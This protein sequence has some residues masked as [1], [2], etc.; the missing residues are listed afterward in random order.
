[1]VGAQSFDCTFSGK[2]M[3]L[4]SL[5]AVGNCQV[6]ALVEDTGSIVWACL[7]SF[8]SEPIF[9]RLLDSNG[10]DFTLGPADGGRGTQRYLENPNVLETTFTTPEGSF[11]VLDFSP[12]FERHSRTFRPTQLLRI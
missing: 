4:E 9:G 6:G 11:R 10:G 2:Q 3:R 5:G 8:D 1:M 7:P 12:R